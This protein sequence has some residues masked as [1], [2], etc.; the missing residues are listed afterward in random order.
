M[1]NATAGLH[2]QLRYCWVRC[3]SGQ[4]SCQAMRYL[5]QRYM[6]VPAATCTLRSARFLLLVLHILREPF[7][8]TYRQN[9]LGT[10]SHCAVTVVILQPAPPP[11]PPWRRC[12]LLH[13]K[14]AKLLLACR[15][16]GTQD[17]VAQHVVCTTAACLLGLTSY[18]SQR[19]P[20]PSMVAA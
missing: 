4:S 3:Q 10:G 2:G 11:L 17:G 14:L 13:G 12:K 6:P 9:C 15:A 16:V 20:L 19:L 18:K 5:A 7:A 1:N 8:S